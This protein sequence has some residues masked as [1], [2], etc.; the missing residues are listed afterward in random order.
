[1]KFEKHVFICINQREEGKACCAAKGSEEILNVMKEEIKKR[2][3]NKKI[4]INKAGCLDMCTKGAAM[5]VYPEGVWYGNVTLEDVPEIIESHL[6]ANKP[7]ERLIA[8]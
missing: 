8:Q 2:G 5:V 3:L 7:V 1:M 4:R 6:I